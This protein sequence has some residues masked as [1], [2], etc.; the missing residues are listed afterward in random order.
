MTSRGKRA[1]LL[2]AW[3]LAGA[4]VLAWLVVPYLVAVAFL[5]DMAGTDSVIRRAIP[6]RTSTV[7]TEDFQIP[8]RHGPLQARLYSPA[9]QVERTAIVFPGVH[10]GGVNEARL[11]RFCGRLASTGALV[12]C[13]PLPELRR[14]RVTSAS[15][16]QIEDV[17]AWATRQPSIAPGGRTA[18]VGVSFAGGLAVVAAGRPALRDR[19]D[20]V[21]AIGGYGDLTR[22]L[23]Y[24]CTGEL[25][26]GTTRQPHEYSLAV[27]A[28]AGLPH[29]APPE[30]T[31]MLEEGIRTYLEASLEESP[32]R[33]QATERLQQLRTGMADWPEPSRSILQAVVDRN[34]EE[35]GRLLLPWLEQLAA[36]PSLSPERSPVP[37]APVFLLHGTDDNVIPSSETPLLAAYLERAGVPH[38]RALLTPL[39]SH[40]GLLD[41]ASARDAWQLVSFWKD[42]LD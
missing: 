14:F 1:I 27:V 40:A 29:L 22:T 4:A 2:A 10:G 19:L 34:R 23:R 5:L 3:L 36:D 16:D 38:V 28:L 41:R 31:E 32:G 6:V 12:L 30:Q 26:D 33:A 18:L 35:V 8:T 15:T 17:T 7:T 37:S 42:V 25:P 11:T 24:L 9:A 13:A 20:L 21:L 39:V